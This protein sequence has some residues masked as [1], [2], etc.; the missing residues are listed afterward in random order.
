MIDMAKEWI[1][2]AYSDLVVIDE[3]ID[4]H[5]VTH[6]VAFHS[7]QAIEKCFK[8]ILEKEGTPLQKI[9]DIRRIHK[10]IADKV[11]L[12]HEQ[13][14][15][16]LTINELYIDSRY[17][18]DIGLLPHGKPTL[19]YA[20]KFYEFAQEIFEKICILLEI[21]LNEIKEN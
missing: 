12:S 9:H 8:A 3:I 19:Q 21:N 1:K 4:N 11:P 13:I 5:F 14:N 10:I 18:G 6:M 17:P 15:T 20:K 7:E 2:A 16:L